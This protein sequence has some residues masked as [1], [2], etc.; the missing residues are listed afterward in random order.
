MA[1]SMSIV[2][3]IRALLRARGMTYRDL[4]HQ[5]GL[6]EP[7][8]KR[9]LGG[10]DFSLSRLDRICEVLDI[11][12]DELVEHGRA[13]EPALTQLSQAQETALV[14]DPKLLLATYLIVND[15]RFE[16]IMQ[17]F[18]VDE[19]DLVSLLLELDRLA[20]IEYRPPD[21]IRKL[22]ARNFAWRRDGPV[23]AFFLG[24][25]MPEF[26]D[27]RFEATGDAF[28]FVGGTLSEASRSRMK[29]AVDRLIGEFEALARQ[30][31]KLP[32]DARDG[33]CAMVALRKWEFSAFTRLRR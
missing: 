9:D 23:H 15:W 7:T 25:I 24:R 14:S 16:Q 27:D 29:T 33:C 21:R 18:R 30:D 5:L 31:A 22:T 19:N 3:A 12:L 1:G 13:S 28:H 6:S 11:S 2:L 8:I 32:F 26:L 20:V 10:G 17:T 4:A